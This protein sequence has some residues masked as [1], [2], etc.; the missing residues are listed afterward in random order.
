MGFTDVEVA[1]QPEQSTG[2]RLST[3]TLR[4]S[5]FDARF[6]VRPPVGIG[7]AT[8]GIPDPEKQ[9]PTGFRRVCIFR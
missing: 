4:S 2:N 3:E 5:E 6:L 7:I 8:L 9:W 1:A